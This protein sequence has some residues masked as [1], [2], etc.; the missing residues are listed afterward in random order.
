MCSLLQSHTQCATSFTPLVRKVFSRRDYVG[1]GV[2]L[3]PRRD[4]FPS[5]AVISS[6]LSRLLSVTVVAYQRF[7]FIA[8]VMLM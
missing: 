8:D 1:V 5:L 2:S 6:V 3:V 4:A 7:L